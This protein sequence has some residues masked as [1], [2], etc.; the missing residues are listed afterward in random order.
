MN[1]T[2]NSNMNIAMFGHKQCLSYEGGVET[3][4]RKL[5]VRMSE[6]NV[7]SPVMIAELMAK[8]PFFLLT[9][10][11]IKISASFRYGQ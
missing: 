10:V 5:S 1:I 6:K 11:V 9:R 3:V 7:P 8:I 2:K 4:V